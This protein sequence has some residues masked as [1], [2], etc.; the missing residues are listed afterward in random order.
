MFENALIESRNTLVTRSKYY[1]F[2]GFTLWSL[3]GATLILVPL[4]HPEALPAT[5]LLSTLIAPPAPTPPPPIHLEK[6][7]PQ[8]NELQ[9]PS[10]IPKAIHLQPDDTAPP[11]GPALAGLANTT[12]PSGNSLLTDIVGGPKVVPA[13]PRKVAVSSGVMRGNLLTR[14]DPVYPAIARQARVEGTVVLSA[15]ISKAGTIMNLTVVSGPPMLAQ[16]AMDAVRQW[17]YKPYLLNGNPVEVQ[18][19]V[20]ITFTLSH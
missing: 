14:P 13:P 8:P 2:A 4:L 16:A 7:V 9:A 3:I 15:T 18:T 17:L 1:T 5:K 19:E 6:A 10:K 12:S 11:S 20:N